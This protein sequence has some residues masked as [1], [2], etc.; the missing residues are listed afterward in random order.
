MP[1]RKT[2]SR[3]KAR[4]TTF[5]AEAVGP[6]AP[7][8]ARGKDRS[9]QASRIDEL[10]WARFDVLIQGLARKILRTF[11]PE[12]VIGVAHGGVFVGGALASA[13]AC[14]FYPVRISRRSRDQGRRKDPRLAGEM[15]EEISGQRVLIVDD[16]ASSGDTLELAKALAAKA[17]ARE[18]KTACLVGRQGGYSPD[19]A[20][21]QTSGLMVFPWDLEPV[22]EDARFDVDP[23]KAGA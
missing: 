14:D 6:S 8:A 21:L 19:W 22:V 5:D 1:G 15:P 7:E 20:P 11:K 9:T 4:E 3:S 23:D 12:A 18:I 17:G 10:T 2:T 13:L 16:V